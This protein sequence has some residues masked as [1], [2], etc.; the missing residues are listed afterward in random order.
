MTRRHLLVP[1]VLFGEGD[2]FDQHSRLGAE[3]NTQHPLIKG[4]N[5]QQVIKNQSTIKT[6]GWLYAT[7]LGLH[8]TTW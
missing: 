7:R 3:E 2:V 6:H 8:G 5:E 1:N 4:K